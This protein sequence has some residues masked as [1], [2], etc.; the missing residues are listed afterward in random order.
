MA[1]RVSVEHMSQSFLQARAWSQGQVHMAHMSETGM[2]KTLLTSF[3]LAQMC[4]TVMGVIIFKAK[5]VITSPYFWNRT[6]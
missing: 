4:E 5:I 2:L 3:Q 6:M 1:E